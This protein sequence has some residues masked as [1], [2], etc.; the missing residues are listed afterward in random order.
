MLVQSL[1]Q[2]RTANLR[3]TEFANVPNEMADYYGK[4]QP[5]ASYKWGV[6]VPAV[7]GVTDTKWS[8]VAWFRSRKR[9]VDYANIRYTVYAIARMK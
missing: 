5:S 7:F 8:A 1:L 4:D 3:H 6:V 2:Y 9:A